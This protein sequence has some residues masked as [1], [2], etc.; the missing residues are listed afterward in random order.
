LTD[1]SGLLQ[2]SFNRST[3]HPNFNVNLTLKF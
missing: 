1:V 3:V 2:G